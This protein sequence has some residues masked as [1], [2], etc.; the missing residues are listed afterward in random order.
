MRRWIDCYIGQVE[1]L[2]F[3]EGLSW[4]RGC[5]VGLTLG[6]T[7]LALTFLFLQLCRPKYAETVPTLPP[8]TIKVLF[9]RLASL[10][11]ILYLTIICSRT[12]QLY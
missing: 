2:A 9:M 7:F 3:L 5:S 1:G 12:A 11:F 4:L 6:V 8:P 10:P